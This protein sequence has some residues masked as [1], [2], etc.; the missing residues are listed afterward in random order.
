MEL[1]KTKLL[2]E[3]LINV[4]ICQFP[5]HIFMYF[6]LSVIAILCLHLNFCCRLNQLKPYRI[7]RLSSVII[8]I[9]DHLPSMHALRSINQVLKKFL[10]LPSLHNQ[11]ANYSQLY[12]Y[13]KLY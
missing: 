12:I 6:V 5:F 3:L 11:L 9:T 13:G 4:K 2:D 10:S 1:V 8:I 7:M